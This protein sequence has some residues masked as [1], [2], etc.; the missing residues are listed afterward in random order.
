MFTILIWI[1]IFFLAFIW[2]F[3]ILTKI[4]AY[5]FK[6]LNSNIE[7]ITKFFF[8]F[9]SILTIIWFILIYY[10]VQENKW[11]TVDESKTNENVYY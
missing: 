6:T 5:K 11:I 1:Y 2:W 8:V 7:K 9:L 4:N 10:L 3:F